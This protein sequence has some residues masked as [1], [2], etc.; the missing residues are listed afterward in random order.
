MQNNYDRVKFLD[1]IRGWG[2]LVVVLYHLFIQ[3]HPISIAAQSVMKK[4]FVFNG[5]LA[6]MLFFVVSGYSLSIGYLKTKDINIIKRIAIGRYF[7]LTIPIFLSCL[8]VYLCTKLGWSPT[9]KPV[10][11]AQNLVDLLRF[12]FY[13]VYANYNADITPIPPLW[14]MNIEWMGSLIVLAFL[15]VFRTSKLRFLAYFGL[16]IWFFK[17]HPF[18]ATFMFGVVLAEMR[19]EVIP[20]NFKKKISLFAKILLGPTLLAAAWLPGK[21]NPQLWV[22]VGC[23]FA[24]CLISMDASMRFFSTRISKFLGSI[25]FPMYLLH[26]PI[27]WVFSIPFLNKASS[28]V[29][30]LFSDLLV[31]VAILIISWLLRGIDTLGIIVAKTMGS[32]LVPAKNILPQEQAVPLQVKA[33]GAP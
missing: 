27:I 20:E 33:L 24:F 13:N 5:F 25:S 9:P 15:V 1:G 30:I 14:T 26:G 16:I 21:E 28:P 18:Y 23:V 3:M 32:L 22:A 12:A 4:F 10:P 7:R 11:T 2:A 8:L 17:Y 31:I 19:Q 6:V 29:E